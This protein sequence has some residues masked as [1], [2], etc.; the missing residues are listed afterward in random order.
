MTDQ[1]TPGE[2]S[3]AQAKRIRPA[4]KKALGR[5]MDDVHLMVA[6]NGYIT[7]GL[8]TRTEVEALADWLQRAAFPMPQRDRITTAQAREAFARVIMEHQGKSLSATRVNTMIEAVVQTLGG[9]EVIE[10]NGS[11]DGW[12]REP[13]G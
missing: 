11:V 5:G 12:T 9:P 7:I 10:V 6:P 2:W 3:E 8:R 4:L 13:V 1:K